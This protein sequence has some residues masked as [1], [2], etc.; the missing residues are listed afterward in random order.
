MRLRFSL[1]FLARRSFQI[2]TAFFL[3]EAAVL[4]SFSREEVVPAIP[5][6]RHIPDDLATWTLSRDLVIDPEGL[7]I[8]QPDDYLLRDYTDAR[9]HRTANLYIAYFKTQRTERMPHSPKNC[10]PGNG[11]IAS[12][13]RIVSLPVDA[14]GAP[15]QLNR[16]VVAKGD[17]RS[18]VLYWYQTWNRTVAS[19]YMARLHLAVDSIRYNRTDTALV[20]IMLPIPEGAVVEEY[21]QT[22]HAFVNAI[23]PHLTGY[24]PSADALSH[25]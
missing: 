25:R 8:L 18:I 13:H 16:Y 3:L 4:H 20:R 2:V 7:S 21:E 15:V 10:L 5:E 11:W 17:Q 14:G 12:E 23:H 9:S 24:F 6:L 22:A 19:E 1:D